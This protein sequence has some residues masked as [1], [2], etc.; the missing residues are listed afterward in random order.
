VS[1]AWQRTT[2]FFRVQGSTSLS[3]VASANPRL[4]LTR[5][6]ESVRIDRQILGGSTLSGGQPVPGSSVLAGLGSVRLDLESDPRFGM[7]APYASNTRFCLSAAACDG[8]DDSDNLLLGTRREFAS[9]TLTETQTL[10]AVPANEITVRTIAPTAYGRTVTINPPGS[11]SNIVLHTNASGLVRAMELPGQHPV[12]VDYTGRRVSAVRQGAY[13][14]SNGVCTGSPTV[15]RSVTLAYDPTRRWLTGVTTGGTQTT[16]ITPHPTRG[17]PEQIGLPARSASDP[18]LLGYHG[19]GNVEFVEGP[20]RTSAGRYQYTYT[21]RALLFDHTTPLGAELSSTTYTLGG[22]RSAQTLLGSASTSTTFDDDGLPGSIAVA[23]GGVSETWT[24][25]YDGAERPLTIA[26]TATGYGSRPGNMGFGYTGPLL[27]SISW[28]PTPG[29]TATVSFGYDARTLR[30]ASE[31]VDVE[32]ASLQLGYSYAVN[33]VGTTS[34]ALTGTATRGGVSALGF[35]LVVPNP[36]VT[37]TPATY[38]T[39]Q[40]TSGTA[41]TTSRATQFGEIYE[42][43]TVASGTVWYLERVCARD[44]HGRVLHRNEWIRTET[45]QYVRHRYY[46]S[47]DGAGRLSATGRFVTT[48]GVTVPT[49]AQS[50]CPTSGGTAVPGSARLWSYNDAGI[51]SNLTAGTDDQV[52]TGG[53]QYDARGRL[54][55]SGGLVTPP[56]RTYTHDALGRLRQSVHT[57]ALYATTTTTFEYDALGRLSRIDPNGTPD[58]ADDEYFW[59]RDDLRPIAWQRGTGAGAVH[60]FFVYLTRSNVP[61][62]MYVDDA[63]TTAIDKVYRFLTDQRG[64]VRAVLRVDGTP[65]VVQRISYDEWGVAT[66]DQGVQTLHPFGFAGG[67]RMGPT[68][69]WHF[70]ARNYDPTIGQWVEKDPIEY[71]GGTG[72]Y[73]YCENDPVNCVDPSGLT[74]GSF[75]APELPGGSGLGLGLLGPGVGLAGLAGALGGYGGAWMMGANQGAVHQATMWG[76]GLGLGVG[77][78]ALMYSLLGAG[79]LTLGTMLFAAGA[80]F[81]VGVLIGATIGYLADNNGFGEFCGKAD[82]ILSGPEAA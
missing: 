50:D 20:G 1:G 15:T 42:T 7:Q 57:N 11:T 61:D 79:G 71:A 80:V 48:S 21:N 70:G 49:E 13:S 37:G 25:T 28:G 23:Q 29:P 68:G 78:V 81:V 51:R 30:V 4:V 82:P 54:S 36:T 27:S 72:P 56:Y 34:A 38:P 65:S 22:A 53:R 18:M 35:S 58:D 52:S 19:S 40:L 47:Y 5:Y 74:G 63:G 41:V 33:N 6:P 9:G 17:W 10:H 45:G 76:G 8:D 73:L 14:I 69:L 46:Y 3:A 66:V 26:H 32:A 60:A 67:V 64:S 77:G 24:A 62:L 75:P 55:R 31:T 39:T 16:T 2:D 12:C 43:R 44:S 59:Y